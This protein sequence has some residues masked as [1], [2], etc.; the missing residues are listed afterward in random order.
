M[1]TGV[2]NRQGFD[3]FFGYL[4]QRH[5]HNYYPSYLWSNETPVPLENVQSATENVAKVR[6]QYAPDLFTTGALEFLDL[7]KGHPFF[8]YLTY[9]LPHANNE[10]GAAEG[11]GMEVPDD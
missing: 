6:K 3:E 4:N 9:I 10:L 11:N 8:L 1:T 5:A 2:P 7:H